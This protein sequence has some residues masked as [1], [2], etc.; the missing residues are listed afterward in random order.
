MKNITYTEALNIA[1]QYGLE[2]EVAYMIN[3]MGASPWE[4][5]Y[6]WD[7]VNYD[8]YDVNLGQAQTNA[9]NLLDK[10]NYTYKNGL[11]RRDFS[12]GIVLVNSSD[13]EQLYIFNNEEFEKING[14]QDRSVNNGSIIN[15]IKIIW[16]F[17]F[18]VIKKDKV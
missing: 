8:E 11:W 3:E 16:R 15:F 1:R 2:G 7:L 10:S 14:T 13:K 18:S 4:A 6:E 9:Y 5:L 12:E 17:T